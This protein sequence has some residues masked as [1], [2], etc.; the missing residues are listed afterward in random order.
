MCN[1]PAYLK[2]YDRPTNQPADRRTDRL[3][4]KLNFKKEHR[5]SW[6]NLVTSNTAHSG[7][8]KAK[9]VYLLLCD[10]VLLPSVPIG[11]WKSNF[12]PFKEIITVKPTYQPT[13][14]QIDG[15]TGS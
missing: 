15:Q 6:D 8:N 1:F 10:L 2:N 14:R 13:S 9:Y 7:L 11:A 12:P 3:I 5:G 4:G